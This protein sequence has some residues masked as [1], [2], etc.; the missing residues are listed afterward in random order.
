LSEK[1]KIVIHVTRGIK[2]V[3]KR[4][5]H[6]WEVKDEKGNIIARGNKS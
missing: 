6:N 5:T 4:S 3:V 1:E 2:A